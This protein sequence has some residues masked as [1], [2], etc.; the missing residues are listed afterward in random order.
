MAYT[1]DFQIYLY[2][3]D[4]G[5][6]QRFTYEGENHH[7][8]VWSPDGRRIAFTSTRE[9]RESDIYVKDVDGR[10]PAEWAV[11]LDGLQYASQWLEGD[12][13]VVFD[14]ETAGGETDILLAPVDSTGEAVPL[15][16][17]DWNETSPRV[18]PDGRLLAYVSNETGE[19]HVYVREF[20]SMAGRWQV[21]AGPAYG[22]LIWSRESDAIYY[23]DQPEGDPTNVVRA[24]L[25]LD[26]TL[27]VLSRTVITEEP[28]RARDMHPDG[29]RLLV[30]RP[31]GVAA[32]EELQADLMVV[33]NWFTQLRERLGEDGE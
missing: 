21:S 8:P 23:H 27:Q 18:S 13:L 31:V 11:G 33:A 1:R 5:T 16:R 15:L 20:P 25:Q 29:R 12:S 19:S 4:R 10:S 32:S 3:L 22:P 7:D 9:G 2:D 24:E 17:A 14:R 28:G 26:P 6:N 30:T